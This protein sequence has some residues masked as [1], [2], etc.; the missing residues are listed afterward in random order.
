MVHTGPF[1]GKSA[2]I[3][4]PQ[5]LV[6]FPVSLLGSAGG[7][8]YSSLCIGIFP[9][10]PHWDLLMATAVLHLLGMS[11]QCPSVRSAGLILS[12]SLVLWLLLVST[13]PFPWLP[14]DAV[15]VHMR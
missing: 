1:L 5:P 12:L 11:P 10:S 3:S 15:N 14:M 4:K 6:L 7:L 13:A 8:V 9:Q 2:V